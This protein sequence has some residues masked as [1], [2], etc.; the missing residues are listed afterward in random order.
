MKKDAENQVRTRIETLNLETERYSFKV[1]AS[2]KLVRPKPMTAEFDT[3]D[4]ERSMQVRMP[5]AMFGGL[6]DTKA[7]VVYVITLTDNAKAES[8]RLELTEQE[9]ADLQIVLGKIAPRGMGM[10]Y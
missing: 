9:L 7:D 8:F 10:S 4:G 5:Q 6:Q 1:V 2:Y 3:G